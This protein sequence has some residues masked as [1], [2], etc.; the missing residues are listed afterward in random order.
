MPDDPRPA[1]PP[2]PADR[3]VLAR[4]RPQ[5]HTP[6]SLFL[7]GVELAGVLHDAA[8]DGLALVLSHPVPVGVSVAV[9][10]YLGAGARELAATVAHAC[11]QDDDTWLVGLRLDRPLPEAQLAALTG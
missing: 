10:L 8:A 6:G 2:G 11:L 7:A 4:V 3:R 1:P 9:T 5:D